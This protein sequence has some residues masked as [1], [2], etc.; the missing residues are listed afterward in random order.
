MKAKRQR[1]AAP[2]HRYSRSG[3][4]LQAWLRQ[5]FEPGQVAKEA[6]GDRFDLREFHSVV[7]SSG[8]LALPVLEKHIRR[9]IAEKL[10]NVDGRG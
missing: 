4:E 6:L 5:N 3:A 7:L 9:Y 1:T 10:K 8:T 2:R